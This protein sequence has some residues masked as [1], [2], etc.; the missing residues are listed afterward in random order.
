[1]RLALKIAYKFTLKPTIVA[2]LSDLLA[3]EEGKAYSV[4]GQ[5]R[6]PVRIQQSRL[7]LAR[8]GYMGASM[9]AGP[10]TVING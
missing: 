5:E 8:K 1:M 9:Y 2:K 10:Y 7:L 3:V 4:A 6:P